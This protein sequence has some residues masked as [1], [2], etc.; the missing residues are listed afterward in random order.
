MAFDHPV[1]AD[2]VEDFDFFSVFV[3]APVLGTIMWV[4]G[5]NEALRQEEEI[6]G[7]RSGGFGSKLG[8]LPPSPSIPSYVGR[9]R[10]M[11][12]LRK[13]KPY[14][15]GSDLSE[16]GEFVESEEASLSEL[17]RNRCLTEKSVDLSRGKKRM[18]WSDEIGQ[19]LVQFMDETKL[20]EAALH[21]SANTAKPIKS[22]MK[23]S[24]S[25][26]T[27]ACSSVNDSD[28]SRCIPKGLDSGHGGLV[29]PTKPY[30]HDVNTR[31]AEHRGTDHVSPEWGWYISTTPPTPEM[32][33]K[34]SKP[35]KKI[36]Y[37]GS[38]PSTLTNPAFSNG[39]GKGA[40]GWPSIPL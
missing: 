21:R 20:G 32:Y 17:F 38:K 36:S 1:E 7:T 28:V 33:H 35:V 13:T 2:R 3:R 27:S 31:H 26:R 9:S 11:K 6:Q 34:Q 14:L 15:I 29:M 5:G 23:R 18:S 25:I 30:G 40:M 19:D 24:R 12:D 4:L 39:A 22:A 37:Q 16:I 10:G 8:S